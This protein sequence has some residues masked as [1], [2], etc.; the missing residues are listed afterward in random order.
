ME[1]ISGIIA[2]LVAII[3]ALGAGLRHSAN[4]NDKLAEAV[5][6][7]EVSNEALTKTNTLQRSRAKIEEDHANDGR[8]ALDTR[9]HNDY[10]D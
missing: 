8:D 4:K 5:K 3:V 7:G 2:A 10:R 1:I 9:L 6:Q